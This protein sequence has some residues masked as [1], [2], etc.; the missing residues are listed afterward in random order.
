MCERHP[1]P[2]EPAGAAISPRIAGKMLL[3][4]AVAALRDRPDDPLALT[5][6]GIAARL[7]RTPPGTLPVDLPGHREGWADPLPPWLRVRF[8]PLLAA[9][10]GLAGEADSLRVA[11]GDELAQLRRA[12]DG[13]YAKTFQDQLGGARRARP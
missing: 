4:A 12:T 11:A 9:A 7:A 5:V 3:T 8:A 10:A 1:R 2:P 6:V 13:E